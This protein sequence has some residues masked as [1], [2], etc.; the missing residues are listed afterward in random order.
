MGAGTQKV[1]LLIYA[2]SSQIYLYSCWRD[3]SKEFGWLCGEEYENELCA[4]EI[5]CEV[6]TG[7]RRVEDVLGDVGWIT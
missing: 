2:M 5:G 4:G 3:I 7:G 6:A 1:D